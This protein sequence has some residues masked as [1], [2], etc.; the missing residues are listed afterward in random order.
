MDWYSPLESVFR[1]NFL[2]FSTFTSSTV[3]PSIGLPLESLTAPFT[4][5]VNCPHS[6]T[7]LNANRSASRVTSFL[8]L[9]IF[10][11]ARETVCSTPLPT[12]R[13]TLF[14]LRYKFMND[15]R[16][17]P[18]TNRERDR[19]RPPLQRPVTGAHNC[20][21]CHKPDPPG[22]SMTT[23]N[24]RARPVQGQ[25]SQSQVCAWQSAAS[26]CEFSP[27]SSQRVSLR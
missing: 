24:R 1:S 4:L 5:A 21:K 17:R 14:L 3:A 10:P 2:P 16:W 20:R 18:A 22:Y 25:A 26:E 19:A 15:P 8:C 11:P 9:F 7:A 13:S 23:L 12:C 27:L 6:G